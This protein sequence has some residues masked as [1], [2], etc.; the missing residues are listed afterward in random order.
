M[1]RYEGPRLVEPLPTA[2]LARLQWLDDFDDAIA[3]ECLD[4]AALMVAQGASP[5]AAC[6]LLEGFY[7]YLTARIRAVVDAQICAELQEAA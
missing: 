7:G 5:L 6:D 4:L 1:H 2:G 3:A